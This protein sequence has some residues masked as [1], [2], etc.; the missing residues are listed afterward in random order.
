MRTLDLAA[1]LLFFALGLHVT[2]ADMGPAPGIQV[3]DGHRFL[4]VGGRRLVELGAPW[5]AT[6]DWKPVRHFPLDAPLEEEV[7]DGGRR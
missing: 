4:A 5:L 7:V 1:F 2:A 3:A 6:G